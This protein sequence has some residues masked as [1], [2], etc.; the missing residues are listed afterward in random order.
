MNNKETLND[1]VNHL[2]SDAPGG[3]PT[4][5]QVGTPS[6]HD[7]LT[8]INSL[9]ET[10]NESMEVVGNDLTRMLINMLALINLL[11]AQGVFGEEDFE[12]AVE[13]AA[14]QFQSAMQQAAG[15]KASPDELKDIDVS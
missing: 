8:M 4:Q 9:D 15:S 5:Q 11:V 6:A 12:K 3:Q 14:T 2:L 10:F 13:T 1:W 7:L